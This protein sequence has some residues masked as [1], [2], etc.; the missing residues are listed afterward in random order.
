[1]KFYSEKGPHSY[2]YLEDYGYRSP[3]LMTPQE[4][5][6]SVL[7]RPLEKY[8]VYL[9]ETLITK[10]PYYYDPSLLLNP[11][12][13]VL[14]TPGAGKSELIKSFIFRFK[15]ANPEVPVVVVDPQ[16]EYAV[17]AEQLREVGIRSVVLNIG[18]GDY[19]NI[20]DRPYPSLDYRTW[21][22]N[23][24]VPSLATALRIAEGAAL[25]RRVLYEA[26]KKAYENAGFK[27]TD[28]KTWDRDDPTLLD[29]VRILDSEVGA[30]F[31]GRIS[32][33]KAPLIR[34]ALALVERLKM[35]VE[36]KGS[37]FFA[38]KST[39]K[40][41]K[42]INEP[43]VILNIK[44]LSEDAKDVF[45]LMLFNYFF[46]LM[47]QSKPI[48]GDFGIRLVTVYDEGWMLLKKRRN[49]ETLL[50]KFFRQ[51]R[52][53]G[54]AC[55]IATQKIKEV[56]ESVLPLSGCVFIGSITEHEGIEKLARAFKLPKW[57]RDKLPMLDRGMFVV[58]PLWLRRDFQNSKTPFIIR[59]ETAIKK[60]VRISTPA[61]ASP[62]E[63]V[64]TLRTA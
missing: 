50:E 38:Y 2:Y 46:Y 64:E 36:G 14:G 21:I 37:D 44:K 23:A 30:Y 45:Q 53:Y 56:S 62:K 18:E 19:L 40:L 34:S 32:K 33:R 52:K 41:S 16:D 4:P 1:M 43:L 27:P 10:T 20:M 61:A 47:Q 12:V 35:W 6:P 58:V 29:V 59:V 13:T 28:P 57:V 22:R 42:L 24:V 49:E 25:M 11:L 8:A 15:I 31:E 51:A 9:G 39:V 54:F 5:D 3:V 17:V 63:F 26:I 60:Q 55:L 48:A 7:V